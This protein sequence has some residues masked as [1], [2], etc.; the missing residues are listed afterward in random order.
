M[1]KLILAT[2]SSPL[3]LWQ[4]REVASMLSKAGFEAELLALE[5]SGDRKLEVSLA[6]I[7]EKGLFTAELEA[8]LLQGKAHLAV[9]SAKDMPS[10]LPDGL[11][12]IAFTERENPED[13]LVSYRPDI[14]LSEPGIRVGTSSTRRT[15]MLAR[16]FPQ[17]VPVTVR[18]NLQT[19]FRKMHEGH[20]DAMILARAGVVRM[21]LGGFIRES[22][23]T[24][25]FTPAA[26]QASLAI[27]AATNIDPL[28]KNAI[29]SAL[30][31]PVSEAC[32]LAERAFLRKMEGGCS[33]PV[34][35]LCRQEN[36]NTFLLEAGIFSS[37][38]SQEVRKQLR[39]SADET[40]AATSFQAAGEQAADEVLRSG[41]KAILEKIK[42]G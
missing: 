5:T 11:G 10:L 9:H 23:P 33:I 17:A 6:K 24:A 26:G 4:A 28:L 2:R 16:Y 12:I 40:V 41:G 20:C 27:E 25:I 1:E 35:A 32:I 14:R 3:A 34:F 37:D 13:V 15:A 36:E 31:H 18:G 29:R 39:F 7:G 42:A 8:L 22:L 38:G 30:N 21:E 19:R